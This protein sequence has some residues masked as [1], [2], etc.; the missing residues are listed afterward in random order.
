MSRTRSEALAA[1]AFEAYRDGNL[2]ECIHT[3]V[4]YADQNVRNKRTAETFKRTIDAELAKIIGEVTRPEADAPVCGHCGSPC[5]Y[6]R[7]DGD[8]GC[9]NCFGI[10][11]LEEVEA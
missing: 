4:T 1:E 7:T 11:P 3:L 6:Y 8:V 2:R 10:M 9:N 5:T